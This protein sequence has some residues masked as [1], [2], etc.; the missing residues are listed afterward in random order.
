MGSLWILS[1]GICPSFPLGLVL[2]ALTRCVKPD[3]DLVMMVKPQFEVGKERLGSGG[4]G[5]QPA[6]ARRGRARSGGQGLGAGDS[7]RRA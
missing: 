3:A 4:S 1:W 2:P 5:P 6:V 7:G